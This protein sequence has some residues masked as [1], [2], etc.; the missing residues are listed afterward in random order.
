MSST[1]SS[2]KLSEPKQA[3][4]NRFL[5]N[6]ST[7]ESDKLDLLMAEFFF[8]CNVPFAACES[9]YFK[10]FINALRPAYKPPN[11]RKLATKLL[12]KTNDK[13]M[14]RNSE[15]MVKMDKQATLLIDGWQNSSANKHNIVTMLATADDHK[16]LLESFDISS[17]RETTE[18]LVEIAEKSIALAEERY[19]AEVYACISDNARNMT[20]MGRKLDGIMFTTCNAHTANLLAGDILK[21]AKYSKIMANVMKVQ[22]EF[23]K[24]G[25]ASRMLSAGGTKAVLSC[26]TRWTSQRGAGVSFL[27]NL[28]AM[29]KVAAD[30][31]LE[32]EQDKNAT[33]PA[34]AVSQ[35]LFKSE[36][37]ESVKNLL[38]ILDPVAELTN[39]CQRSD[40]SSADAVEKW[41]DLIQNSNDELRGYVRQRT[42]KSK[43]FNEITMT[44]NFFHP[45]YRGLKLNETQRTSVNDFIFESSL[46]AEGLESCRLYTANEGTFA[47]LARK[48]ITS[49]KTYWH[50]AGQ[51]DHHKLSGFAMKLLKI[52]AS[53]AQLERLFSNWAYVHNDIRNRL[54]VETSNKLVNV[55]FTLRANDQPVESDDESE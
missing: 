4:M 28:A 44:A 23:R 36:F 38:G 2:F 37:I 22:K 15:M 13:I 50:F 21:T 3:R 5:D 43:V 42:V 17:S 26:A 9:E 1:A 30:C 35:L 54:S 39:N 16:V 18:N 27:K 14:K 52:P 25:L 6:M 51:Q 40:C 10:K 46:D 55:Y 41:L 45:V 7:G 53:T 32:A 8:G 47:A 49:P 19:G 48:K 33:R 34:E 12:D 24:T 20:S 29:K 31:D 11:R